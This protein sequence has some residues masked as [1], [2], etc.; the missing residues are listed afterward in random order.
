MPGHPIVDI[1]NTYGCTFIGLV[2]SIL[3]FGITVCQTWIY[4]WQYSQ[5]DPKPL[6]FFVLVLLLLD[7]FHTILC[8]YSVYWYL[9]LNFGNVENLEYN[10]WT[11]NVT[12]N[13]FV[14]YLVQLFYARRLYIVSKSIIIPTIIVLLGTNCL[15]FGFVF[16]ARSSA[17][18]VFSRYNSLIGITCI[19]LGSSVVADILIAFSMCWYLYHKRTGFAR[20]DSMIMTLMSYSI[21]S[22]LLTCTN[23]M[24]WEIFFWPMGKIYANSLLAMLNS[25]DHL[26]ERSTT[27]K[28]ENAYGL[29][30]FRIA[31]GGTADKCGSKP[32]AVSISVHHSQTTDF[33]EV[34]HNHDVE[35]ATAEMRKI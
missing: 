32:T 27:D 22:G 9:I 17:L 5:R 16:T 26:R 1:Q 25:R 14:D 8:I 21:N 10:V 19:G 6:R 34:K 20:T 2:I 30:S 23:S 3:L 11:M 18:R 28:A 4:F 29:S 24:I 7:T 31:Q 12:I 33:P 35:S 15:A 13:S